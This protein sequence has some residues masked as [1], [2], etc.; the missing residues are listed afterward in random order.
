VPKEEG[1]NRPGQRFR[2][3]YNPWVTRTVLINRGQRKPTIH[4]H[5]CSFITRRINNGLRLGGKYEEIAVD[6]VP[7]DARPCHWCAA[8]VDPK[9]QL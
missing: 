3:S 5:N 4:E 2:P 8:P 1:G 6:K 7:P 9:R